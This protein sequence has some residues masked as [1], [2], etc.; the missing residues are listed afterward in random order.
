[1]IVV[2]FSAQDVLATSVCEVGKSIFEN[3]TPSWDTREFGGDI[4]TMKD[5][6]KQATKTAKALSDEERA[7]VDTACHEHKDLIESIAKQYLRPGSGLELRDLIQIGKLAMIQSVRSWKKN[8]GASFVTIANG[9]IRNAMRSAVPE[10]RRD[11]NSDVEGRGRNV[12]KSTNVLY[13]SVSMFKIGAED[14]ESSDVLDEVS[15]LIAETDVEGEYLRMEEAAALDKA[16]ASL[17]SNDEQLVRLWTEL[18]A[19]DEGG[20]REIAK[21]TGVSRMTAHR[22]LN[23]AL[24]CLRDRLRGEG[25]SK[26]NADNE[27]LP[28]ILQQAA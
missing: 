10:A 12:P 5:A 4:I 6:K 19:S 14:E 17:S 7:L 24:Q 27:D 11:R 21:R 1:M 20:I 15:A 3:D 22:K 13:A 28:S 8:G 25:K 26:S 9:D 18:Q 23:D 2:D 16:L